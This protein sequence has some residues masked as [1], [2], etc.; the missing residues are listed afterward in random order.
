METS[1]TTLTEHLAAVNGRF[2][3][4]QSVIWAPRGALAGLLIAAVVATVARLRPLLTNRELGLVALG[5]MALGLV[6]GWLWVWLKRPSLTEQA[7]LADSELGLQERAITAVELQQATIATTPWLAEKQL[8]DVVAKLQGINLAE[9][10]PL[11]WQRRD[12]L[13]LGL[14]VML[15]GTAVFLNNPQ[16]E[17]L[18]VQRALSQSL[19][20]EATELEAL[21]EEISQNQELSEAEQEELLAPIEEA[22]DALQAGGTSQEQA[23]ATLSQAEE[24]LREL[25]EELSPP[26]VQESLEASSE[27]LAENEASEEL[28]EAFQGG[29]LNQASSATAQLAEN[30]PT[31]NE[32]TLSQLADALAQTSEALETSDQE[33]SEAFQE[34]ANALDSQNIEGAQAALEDLAESL[35]EQAEAQEAAQQA[36]AAANQLN[37]SRQEIAQAGAS[38]TAESDASAQGSPQAGD[39]GSQAGEGG[40]QAGSEGQGQ[41]GQGA[42]AEL[43]SGRGSGQGAG[44]GGGNSETVFVPDAV[45]LSTIE[46]ED[47]ELPAE[48]Q[49]NPD[50]CGGLLNETPTEF[51][52]ETS[53]VPYTDVF[54]DY[55][56]AANEALSDDYIP[57]GLKGYVRDY[58]SS[59]EP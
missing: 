14:A 59:L 25:S 3:L 49:A 48:C 44:P 29:N 7:Q 33:L 57:L 31:F 16:T 58:F 56:D 20:E 55:Q 54:G 36:E 10:M 2:R 43:D 24:E 51:G 27:T 26:G 4:Q 9:A 47:V 38:E 34:A 17:A 35:A 28:A 6:A 52:D 46:G 8:G 13:L 22:L 11:V 45:D 5:L 1:F 30:L 37:E 39:A 12:W 32:E 23:V 42:T 53:L 21:A 19:A 15:V 41:A 40:G 18:A 50:D